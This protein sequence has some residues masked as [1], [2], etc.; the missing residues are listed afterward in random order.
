MPLI[1]WRLNRLPKYA[2]LV[3]VSLIVSLTNF[4]I[5]RIIKIDL[6]LGLASVLL[7]VIFIYL[8]EIQF[9]KKFFLTSLFL[10]LLISIK[11]LVSGIDNNLKVLTPNQQKKLD[12]RHGYFANDLGKLFQNKFALRFYKDIHPYLN[13]Y[14]SN[15]FNSLSPN[16]YFFTNHPRERERVEEF[17]MYPS[18][19]IIPFLIGLIYF[20]NSQGYLILGYTLFAL[21]VTGFVRQSYILGPVLFFP[22]INL[23]I[24]KGFLKIYQLIKR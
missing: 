24:S 10:L 4:W 2:I 17:S 14:V 19:L 15:L 7:S 8:V 1:L 23:L 12:E 9:N 13:V 6:L 18:I 21:L 22:L 11:I 16:L 20:L 5:W 3:F